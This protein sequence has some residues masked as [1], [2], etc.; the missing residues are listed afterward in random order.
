[1]NKTNCM[2]GE[3][4]II[5]T[6]EHEH[7]SALEDPVLHG[8]QSTKAGVKKELQQ[9]WS[10]R[11]DIS[12]INGIAIK[13]RMV[14]SSSLQEKALKQPHI[15]HVDIEGTRLLASKSIYWININADTEET[16]KTAPYVLIFK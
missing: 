11:D 3:E 14:I 12:I 5:V 2:T 6:L 16:I 10:F 4:I 13:G 7:I 8:W 9:F 15:N 1:M